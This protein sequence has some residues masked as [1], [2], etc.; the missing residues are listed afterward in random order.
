MRH[1]TFKPPLA[2]AANMARN[3]T[4]VRHER[5]G[6]FAAYAASLLS[7]YFALNYFDY[8]DLEN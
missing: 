7:Y 6:P 4:S 5:Y 1:E 8:F 3:F 2:V